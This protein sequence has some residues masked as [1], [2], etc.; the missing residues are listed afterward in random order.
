MGLESILASVGSFI[1][2][3]VKI[4][5]S[6]TFPFFSE[7]KLK[8]DVIGYCPEIYFS[9]TSNNNEI[10]SIIRKS[11]FYNVI[12]EV[13]YDNEQQPCPKLSFEKT[14]EED[15]DVTDKSLLTIINYEYV[16]ELLY[17]KY[18]KYNKIPLCSFENS[19][20]EK[21]QK[22]TLIFATEHLPDIIEISVKNA[23]CLYDLKG[24]KVN[25][26]IKPEINLPNKY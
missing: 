2:G 16:S 11:T 5:I 3:L 23:N 17:F 22:I 9:S 20:I 14:P 6:D 4:K 18:Y 13:K 8:R 24:R 21:N 25:S 10:K 12:L 1:M 7:K 15:V 26:I 19:L